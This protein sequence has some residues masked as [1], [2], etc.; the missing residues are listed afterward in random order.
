MTF[1]F[2]KKGAS[3]I[4]SK[5]GL[6]LI[7][8]IV[9]LLML[10]SGNILDLFKDDGSFN[11][12]LIEGDI[13]QCDIKCPDIKY[14]T[15][16][17][18]CSDRD[19]EN[20]GKYS[21]YYERCENTVDEDSYKKYKC[22]SKLFMEIDLLINQ[23]TEEEFVE[24]LELT[25]EESDS[26]FEKRDTCKRT[27]RT[28][29]E[30][31]FMSKTTQIATQIGTTQAIL[32]DVMDF[33]SGGTFCSCALNP[34][35]G[36]VGLIQFTEVVVGELGTTRK[37]LCF[38][39]RVDQLDYVEKYFQLKMT[40]RKVDSLDTLSD[41]YMAVLYPNGIGK[42]DDYVIFKDGS[43]SYAQNKGLDLD[44]NGEVTVGEATKKAFS[45]YSDISWV[46]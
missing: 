4:F 44:T 37:D 7:T 5:I 41:V 35:S 25:K 30:K 42:G 18:E 17:V 20:W 2:N 23:K 22:D 46:S 40:Q 39:D 27:S 14:C 29:L 3:L 26:F 8:I 15:D 36:A 28:D 11:M 32:L 1:L 21:A 45:K 33:E 43:K 16:D 34:K 10:T 38:M 19:R 9:I 12:A 24:T 31:E 6:L 13:L